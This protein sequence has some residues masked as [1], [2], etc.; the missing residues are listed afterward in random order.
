MPVCLSLARLFAIV[1]KDRNLSYSGSCKRFFTWVGG[2]GP[3][4]IT[5]AVAAQ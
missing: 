4:D 3:V 2:S 1:G 5:A